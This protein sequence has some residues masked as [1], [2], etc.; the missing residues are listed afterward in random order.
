MTLE[1]FIEKFNNDED[2]MWETYCLTD[3]T[4]LIVKRDEQVKF[5][6]NIYTRY[7]LLKFFEELIDTER[8]T[9]NAE[10]LLEEYI[11]YSEADYEDNK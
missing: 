8:L 7:H 4:N 11:E 3:H 1:Q 10:D 5:K 9:G 2:E 6:P